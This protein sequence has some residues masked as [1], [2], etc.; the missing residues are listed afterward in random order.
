MT[1]TAA[2]IAVGEFAASTDAELAAY[3]DRL[4]AETRANLHALTAAPKRRNAE[5]PASANKKPPTP[6]TPWPLTRAFLRLTGECGW[7]PARYADLIART[8]QA[9]R[10][11]MTT[12]ATRRCSR[13]DTKGVLTPLDHDVPR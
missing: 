1:R 11:D 12:P 5:R 3:R 2:T 8:L 6:S 9:A 4:P 10:D 13:E 7:T